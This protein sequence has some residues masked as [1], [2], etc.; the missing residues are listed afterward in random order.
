MYNRIEET[1]SAGRETRSFERIDV[2]AF[3]GF[4]V[5]LGPLG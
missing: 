2:P 1:P 5:A 4:E 3:G